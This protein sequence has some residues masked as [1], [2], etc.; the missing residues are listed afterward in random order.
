[1]STRSCS[2]RSQKI[3]DAQNSWFHELH[4]C[5]W[6]GFMF[7]IGLTMCLIQHFWL[8]YV[9]DR[10]IAKISM[11]D[12]FR[13][14]PC[15]ILV[16]S[17]CFGVTLSLTVIIFGLCGTSFVIP[18]TFLISMWCVLGLGSM[19]P[20][21]CD[22]SSLARPSSCVGILYVFQRQASLFGGTFG[23]PGLSKCWQ[24]SRWHLVI[25]I[26]EFK[27]GLF[28]HVFCDTIWQ[29]RIG[30]SG[31]WGPYVVWQ[32]KAFRHMTLPFGKMIHPFGHPFWLYQNHF[33]LV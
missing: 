21:Q 2:C 24:M 8:M 14:D 23:R 16:T 22:N 17:L 9:P 12:R 29:L 10:K 33:I 19:H 4:R 3:W 25:G 13:Q 31:M 15:S 20:Y 18:T 5:K 28:I 11:F 32:Q 6:C 1:M 26:A 7:Y 30:S 27:W